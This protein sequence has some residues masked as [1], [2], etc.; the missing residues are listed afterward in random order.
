MIDKQQRLPG[1]LRRHGADSF[2]ESPLEIVVVAHQGVRPH[3]HRRGEHQGILQAQARFGEQLQR[4]FMHVG[5]ERLYGN[6]RHRSSVRPHSP[7]LDFREL[8][9]AHG[10]AALRQMEEPGRAREL[11]VSIPEPRGDILHQRLVV[12]QVG[13]C[14]IDLP[15]LLIQRL[16]AAMKVFHHADVDGRIRVQAKKRISDEH[17]SFGKKQ[18]G[19]GRA[20]GFEPTTSALY[21]Q[22]SAR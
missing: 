19:L 7:V 4:K 1:Y 17:R 5:C 3:P 8:R 11:V 22:R 10:R 13:P 12:E 16:G 6:I 21:W 15:D 18:A 2:V 9:E 14:I 20:A